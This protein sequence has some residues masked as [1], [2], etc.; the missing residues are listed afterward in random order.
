ML[1]AVSRWVIDNET[2]YFQSLR[3]HGKEARP[4]SRIPGG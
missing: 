2:S 3:S 1:N 4:Y